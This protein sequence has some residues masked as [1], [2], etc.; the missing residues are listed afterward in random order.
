[1]GHIIP[2]GTGF[3]HHRKVRLKPL[4]EVEGE[5]EAELPAALAETALNRPLLPLLAQRLHRVHSRGRTSG[6]HLHGT[7]RTEERG[8]HLPCLPGAKSRRRRQQWACRQWH[9]VNVSWS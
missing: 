9:R 1:M 5:P 4:V 3:D 6:Q 2:A 7:R 8:P